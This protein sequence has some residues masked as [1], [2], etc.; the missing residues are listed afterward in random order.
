MQMRATFSDQLGNRIFCVGTY[1]AYR[2][3]L[4]AWSSS[5]EAMGK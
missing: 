3:F 1:Q 5:G 4:S 2:M